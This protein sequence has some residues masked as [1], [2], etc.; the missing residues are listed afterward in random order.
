M[1]L[2]QALA[3]AVSGLHANQ[4]GMSVVAGNVANAQTPGYVRKTVTQV[5]TPIGT[6]GSGVRVTAIAR[7]L[8]EFVQ[9]QL[10]TETAGGS[11]ADLRAQFYSRLQQVY[12]QPGSDTSIDA[13]FNNFTSA[14]QAL[15]AS[16][17]DFSAQSA[18]L[19]S[20]QLLAQQLN[21]MSAS[22]QGLRTDAE[23]G[24]ASAVTTANTA[25]QQIANINQQLAV[26]GADDSTKANLLDQRDNYISQL[27]DLMDITVTPSDGDAVLVSTTS[28]LQLV[29]LKASVLS[30]QANGS[31]TPDAQYSADP[32]K[33]GV[34]TLTMTTASG[35]TIDLVRTNS[36]R[37]G[38][39]AAYVQ[40]RDSDLV[41]AQ[42]QL[43]AL[44]ASMSQALSD[45]TTAGTAVTAGPQ[46]GF[47]LDV[48]ALLAGNSIDVSYTDGLNRA[49]TI[50]LVRVDD[51]SLLPLPNTAGGPKTVG[52]DFSQGFSHVV[53]QITSALA[54]AGIT[55]SNPSGT[56]IQMLDDGG[57][58]LV[59]IKAASTTTTTTSLT[60]GSAALPLFNDGGISFSNA[61]GPLGRQSVGLAGRITVNSAL[62]SDPS[63]LVSY[64]SGVA[65]ADPTRPNF[66]YQQ[67]VDA[68]LGFDSSSGIGTP[69]SPY[70]GT[71][72]SY[73][74]QV[75]AKQGEAASN[76]DT[77]SQGQ[78]VVLSSLQSR[79][80]DEAS[81]NID[82]EMT[83]LLN[84]QNAYAANARVMSVVKD[85]LDMLMKM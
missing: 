52:I 4:V 50:K 21:S 7:Q 55:V 81:V 47:T 49:Q 58:G 56:T 46:S 35:S 23:N 2:T 32:T 6:A 42:N 83:T 13:T 11:Y 77:L 41:E 29:G 10:R 33:N 37:S 34:G 76:A 15:T 73:L 62:L 64:A 57:G 59:K 78:A 44:A 70:T 36:I 20:A 39:I 74:N 30:F 40:M 84:L 5:S 16:P 65:A 22:V 3:A 75:I 45:K 79:F 60:A 1:S 68:R 17:E 26:G 25:M 19:G 43:D 12:G 28:G 27:A 71:L 8:D 18:V 9:K 85:M 31:I 80:S 53:Q 51:P 14:L 67:M 66:I 72:G 82:Q 38:Q 48:G 61:Y 63:K 69:G 54:N 24:I